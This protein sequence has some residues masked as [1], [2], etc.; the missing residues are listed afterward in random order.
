MISSISLVSAHKRVSRTGYPVG[1][2][3][4]VGLCLLDTEGRVLDVDSTFAHLTGLA[5]ELLGTPFA[6]LLV[7]AP[8]P[9]RDEQPTVAL[10]ELEHGT[11]ELVCRRVGVGPVAHAVMARPFGDHSELERQLRVARQ[12]LDSIIEA[13]PL[14]ILSLDQNKRVVVWNAASERTFGW[15]REEILGQPYPLVPLEQLAEF[16]GLFDQV[17]MQG[18]GFTG[19]ESTRRHKDGSKLEVRMH[20]APLRDAEGRTVGGMALLEDLSETRRLEEQ[21]RHSQKMEATGRLAG[22][23]AHDFN[24]LLTVIVGTCDLLELDDSLSADAQELVSEILEVTE[25]ASELIAQLMTFSRRQVVRPELIELNARLREAVKLIE[26]LIGERIALELELS[27]DDLDVTID[28]TQFDQVLVN[29]AV[30]AADAMRGGGLLWIRTQRREID[31]PAPAPLSPG[32]YAV[33]EVRDTGT[34]IPAEIL[35]HVFEPFFTTKEP[36]EGTGLGLA[37]VYGIVRQAGGN[38]EVESEEGA[39]TTLRVFLPI[40]PRPS[41]TREE[42]AQSGTIPRGSERIL[43]VEDSEAVRQ[44]TQRLLETLGYTVY[45]ATD[46]ADALEKIWQNLEVDLVLS[47]VAMPHV[48]GA[49]LTRQ[50]RTRQPELPIVLMSG[51]LDV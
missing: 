5:G 27:E 32:A 39:G 10:I 22:G 48:D 29:L 35:S 30:N 17:V 46:G 43:L 28:P 36:G 51:N 2:A 20:T 13:S 45:S 8:R 47:D 37:N 42:V 50:L 44:S 40:V 1:V 3:R 34:G 38:V 24:N 16:E 12:T 6:E 21:I 41:A 9:P 33:L 18:E 15:R 4:D 14:S 25:S 31:S 7:D 49:E 11:I 23:I 26:R 19:V